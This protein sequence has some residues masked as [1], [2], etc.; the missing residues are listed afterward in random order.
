MAEH[1]WTIDLPDGTQ[2]VVESDRELTPAE[3]DAEVSN[4]S[5]QHANT[6]QSVAASAGNAAGRGAVG[7]VG[8]LIEGIGDLG[9]L[10]PGLSDNGF[11][12]A[13]RD[14]K[15]FGAETFPVNPA[16]QDEFAVKA[17]E[18][19]GG[20]AE[21]VLE[22]ATGA[23]LLGAAGQIGRVGQMAAGSMFAKGADAGEDTARQFEVDDDP[24]KKAAFTLAGGVIEAGTEKLGGFGAESALARR[25]GVGGIGG[26]SVGYGMAVGQE[27]GEEVAANTLNNTL[28]NAAVSEEEAAA[29]GQRRPGY[30]EGN[31]EAGALGG[32][33]GGVMSLPLLGATRAPVTNLP[34]PAGFT[35]PVQPGAPTAPVVRPATGR[36]S[37]ESIRPVAAPAPITEEELTAMEAKAPPERIAVVAGALAVAP[38]PEVEAEVLKTA[39]IAAQIEAKRQD[40]APAEEV[41]VPVEP[42]A[43]EPEVLRGTSQDSVELTAPIVDAGIPM[44]EIPSV[45]PPAVDM[46]IPMTEG[47]APALPSVVTQEAPILS[48][49]VGS[50]QPVIDSAGALIPEL[51]AGAEPLTIETPSAESLPNSP[52]E[53][54]IEQSAAQSE[55]PA[56]GVVER[57][58]AWANRTIVENRGQLLSGVPNPELLAAYAVKGSLLVARGV[59]DFAA[60][61]RD[62]VTEFGEDVR[63]YLNKLFAESSPDVT[64]PSP[65]GAPGIFEKWFGFDKRLVNETKLYEAR[66]A[67]RKALEVPLFD[68][69]IENHVPGSDIES[70]LSTLT[71]QQRNAL[72]DKINTDLSRLTGSAEDAAKYANELRAYLNTVPELAGQRNISAADLQ[73][74]NL[75]QAAAALSSIHGQTGAFSRIMGISNDQLILDTGTSALT[76]GDRGRLLGSSA[77]VGARLTE[78]MQ[79]ISKSHQLAFKAMGFTDASIE[80]LGQAMATRTLTANEVEDIFASANTSP[81]GPGVASALATLQRIADAAAVQAETAD[82]TGKGSSTRK[83]KPKSLDEYAE[84]LAEELLRDP[85]AK[86]PPTE[87][88]RLKKAIFEWMR[89][90]T[91]EAKLAEILG[92]FGLS[93]QSANLLAASAEEKRARMKSERALNASLRAGKSIL[94]DEIGPLVRKLPVSSIVKTFMKAPPEHRNSAAWRQLQITNWLKNNGIDDALAARLSV[95]MDEM[96]SRVMANVIYQEQE[97]YVTRRRG[98]GSQAVGNAEFAEKYRNNKESI[99][100]AIRFGLMT[101]GTPWQAWFSSVTGIQPLTAAEHAQIATW[102]TILSGDQYFPSEKGVASAKLRDLIDRK[103]GKAASGW[104]LLAAS[105]DAS[106]LSSGTTM[107]VQFSGPVGRLAATLGTDL[108][109]GL[110]SPTKTRDVMDSFLSAVDVYAAELPNAF[111]YDSGG[112]FMGDSAVSLGEVSALKR[113][114]ARQRAVLANPA[115]TTLQKGLAVV[116]FARSAQDYL[117]QAMNAA[118]S[119]SVA[120]FQRY[121]E[122]REVRSLMRKSGISK[123][124]IATAMKADGFTTDAIELEADA[125]GYDGTLKRRYVQDRQWARWKELVAAHK[126]TPEAH[127][128]AMSTLLEDATDEADFQAFVGNKRDRPSIWNVPDWALGKAQQIGEDQFRRARK[129]IEDG[130][131]MEGSLQRIFWRGMLGFVGIPLNAARASLWYSPFAL[132]SFMNYRAWAKGDRK[133]DNPYERSL[134]NAMQV[135]QRMK[136]AIVGNAILAVALAALKEWQDDDDWKINGYGPD[137]S[138]FPEEA[139]AWRRTHTPFAIEKTDKDGKV[140]VIPFQRG[141]LE[142]LKAPL[143]M[144]AG[145]SDATMDS[146]LKKEEALRPEMALWGA[147]K[148]LGLASITTGMRNIG[149]MRDSLQRGMTVNKLGSQAGFSLSPLL[150]YSGSERWIRTWSHPEQLELGLRSNLPFAHYWNDLKPAINMFGQPLRPDPSGS[151]LTNRQFSGLPPGYSREITEEDQKVYGFMSKT[152]KQ[153]TTYSRPEIEKK[154]ERVLTDAEWYD[155]SLVSGK[156]RYAGMLQ[157]I[158]GTLKI[159]RVRDGTKKLKPMKKGLADIDPDDKAALSEAGEIL[160]D[161]GAAAHQAGL[162]AIKAKEPVKPKKKKVSKK[163]VY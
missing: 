155:Y 57:A 160:E 38:T 157:A 117:R 162:D 89:G 133:K 129:E 140:T 55:T 131:A 128:E 70:V 45:A 77:G 134:G 73:Y 154:V 60:W 105:Y 63:P 21:Q 82:P 74:T 95:S 44:S 137:A 12:Q 150:P 40:T 139:K 27:A 59:R 36:A 54:P 98:V 61:S 14:V 99:R 143:M 121:F 4:I 107:A 102:E 91:S 84:Q 49:N 43:V 66:K 87:Q 16:N 46:G 136:E 65:E 41:I 80:A 124:E 114:M 145:V 39:Q 116:R 112:N 31:L 51:P 130:N 81:E 8:S 64:L 123:A 113:D 76:R 72:H 67:T 103:F 79:I 34:P 52:A 78:F 1:E 109:L 6:G 15:A 100:E 90:D 11:Q 122:T 75:V 7:G 126:D 88:Q 108:M 35:A 135:R 71:E 5:N 147:M 53:A 106:A 93:A 85:K 28:V 25:F 37:V 94:D 101:D 92:S 144:L 125:L 115:S 9:S 163:T 23:K 2:Y 96:V 30:L 138:R 24:W 29:A 151:E 22:Y 156:A 32:V 132:L 62:M 159:D 111:K 118:D 141:T 10:I 69:I 18:V 42:P 47:A 97:K 83:T 56:P 3:L 58:E 119:A 13:G 48:G 142:P 146:K 153:P 20:A 127:R 19:V 120:G 152:G 158:D 149:G 104:E 68:G 86:V 26:P 50:V 17:G 110:G 33:A 161:I 148:Q